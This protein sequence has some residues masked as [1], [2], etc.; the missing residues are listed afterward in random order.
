VHEGVP[1]HLDPLLRRWIYA[2]LAGG[3]AEIVALTLEIRIDFEIVHGDAA[4]FLGR[5]PQQHELL[6]IVNVIL[7]RGGPWPAP[8]RAGRAPMFVVTPARRRCP[9]PA[10]GAATVGS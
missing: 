6:G 3:G 9:W 8:A 2:A 4:L 5:D 10:F 1:D 7:S